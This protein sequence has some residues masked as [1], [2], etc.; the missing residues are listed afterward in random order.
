M[1]TVLPGTVLMTMLTICV[2]YYTL[3]QILQCLLRTSGKKLQIKGNSLHKNTD[4]VKK[5]KPI[6]QQKNPKMLTL[7]FYVKIHRM[8]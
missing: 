5:H 6:K 4:F 1:P 3:T 7:L 8:Q 2:N